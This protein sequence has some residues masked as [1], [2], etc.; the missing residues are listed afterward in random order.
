VC[1]NTNTSTQTLWFASSFSSCELLIIFAPFI[2][3]VKLFQV[4]ESHRCNIM[5]EPILLFSA[6]SENSDNYVCITTNQ[7]DTKSNPN[8][9]PATKQRA[10]VRIQPNIVTC[11]TQGRRDVKKS[12]VQ[13]TICPLPIPNKVFQKAYLHCNI[14]PHVFMGP[15]SGHGPRYSVPPVPPSRWPWSHISREMHTY[16]CTVFLAYFPLSLYLSLR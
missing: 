5:P 9:N 3:C 10:V 8:P 15:S 4:F 1:N 2:R 6:I 16:Y 12:P 7:P 13:V 14:V 11:L